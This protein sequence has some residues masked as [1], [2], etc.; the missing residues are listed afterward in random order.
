MDVT[1]DTF[2]PR[3]WPDFRRALFHRFESELDKILAISNS[4]RYNQSVT[5]LIY[6]IALCIMNVKKHSRWPQ[7]NFRQ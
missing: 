1:V 2:P 7:F 3:T 5:I 4:L 6:K